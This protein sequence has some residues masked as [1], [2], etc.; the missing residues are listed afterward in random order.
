MAREPLDA[1][2]ARFA[3]L[4][5][6]AAPPAGPQEGATAPGYTAAEAAHQFEAFLERRLGPN[7]FWAW[8]MSYP[9]RRPGGTPDPGV[10]D[11][12]DRAIVALRALQ[13]GPRDWPAVAAGLRG[14]RARLTGLAR[15]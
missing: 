14:A 1:V 3:G 12:L 9:P 8:L 5:G 11:E 2:T 13:R 7:E 15:G 6:R 4:R 10:E